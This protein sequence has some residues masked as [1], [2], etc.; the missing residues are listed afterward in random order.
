MP[1]V[2]P[3]PPLAN[4][5][6]LKAHLP[7]RDDPPRNLSPGLPEHPTNLVP[8]RPGTHSPKVR[9]IVVRTAIASRIAHIC[10]PFA[11][12]SPEIANTR[13]AM[14]IINFC[15]DRSGASRHSPD[16][17]PNRFATITMLVIKIAHPRGDPS[18]PSSL[19][20]DQ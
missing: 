10:N 8:R 9:V 12:A 1:S 4:P 7:W 5:D 19:V 11:I 17:N 15:F 18:G 16:S 13:S 14:E 20:P 2:A 3:F 6:A